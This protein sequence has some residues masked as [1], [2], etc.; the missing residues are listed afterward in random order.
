MSKLNEFIKTFK[1]Y[2]KKAEELGVMY[3][4]YIHMEEEA[5]IS[6]IKEFDDVTIKRRRGEYYPFAAET[7]YGGIELCAI[8]TKE[9]FKQLIQPNRD[10][11]Y[12]LLES[13]KGTTIPLEEVA[14]C[15]L[16]D[17][18]AVTRPRAET[19]AI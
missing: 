15:P 18:S 12:R 5:F 1:D 14:I 11:Y 4:S 2:N 8:F 3:S 9:E 7:V 13:D 16:S 19:K 10:I 6:F 17:S